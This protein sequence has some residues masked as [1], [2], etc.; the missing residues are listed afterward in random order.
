MWLQWHTAGGHFCTT[1]KNAKFDVTVKSELSIRIWILGITYVFKTV[2]SVLIYRQLWTRLNTR[3]HFNH[4]HPRPCQ[5]RQSHNHT[6]HRHPLFGFH[7]F[8]HIGTF[9]AIVQANAFPC[10][11]LF[12]ALACKKFQD[13]IWGGL[14][15]HPVNTKFWW[16]FVFS[17]SMTIWVRN[18][19]VSLQGFPSY[20]G[21]I[22]GTLNV[23]E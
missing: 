12:L 19:R 10:F 20:A 7:M 2:L 18:V 13:R 5:T 15:M 8:V 4:H 23:L 21:L 6:I 17:P 11:T 1:C 22:I 9:K 3:L 14:P 16:T